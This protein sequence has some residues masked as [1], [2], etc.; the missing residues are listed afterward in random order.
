MVIDSDDNE[1]DQGTKIG[2][3]TVRQLED[4]SYR[5][6]LRV[7]DERGKPLELRA[8]D[9]L[10]PD[11]IQAL[12]YGDTLVPTIAQDLCGQPLIDSLSE[13]PD[14][15]VVDHETFLPLHNDD[16]PVVYIRRTGQELEV[17]VGSNVD[18]QERRSEEVLRPV[19]GK[20]EP[21]VLEFARG[22]EDEARQLLR[23]KFARLFEA[24]DLVE[25]F[26]RVAKALDMLHEQQSK[27][28]G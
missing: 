18:P 4:G 2:F 15:I 16:R 5:A 25:P 19:A 27:K 11:R 1:L 3:L 20:F 7:T 24:F 13:R 14:I 9:A 12:V 23:S 17:D 28:G 10:R 8:T 22:I 6:G 21:V 26:D